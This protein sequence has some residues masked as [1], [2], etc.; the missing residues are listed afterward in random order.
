MG[1]QQQAASAETAPLSLED[2]LRIARQ[3]ST[4]SSS[5]GKKPGSKAGSSSSAVAVAAY[6]QAQQQD[7]ARRTAAAAAASEA[8]PVQFA[9]WKDETI[10]EEERTRRRF[11]QGTRNRTAIACRKQQ[12]RG[13]LGV[14]G[15]AVRHEQDKDGAA[16]GVADVTTAFSFGFSI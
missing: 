11:G 4:A 10:T 2:R 9:S 13:G 3:R 8:A 12:H 14:I 6:R 16:D 15:G 5:G 7:A 1:Q